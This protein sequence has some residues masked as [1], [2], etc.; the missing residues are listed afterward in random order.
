MPRFF[1]FDPDQVAQYEAAGWR[2]YYDRKWLLLLRLLLGLCQRQFHIPFPVSLLAAYHVVRAAAAWAPADHDSFQVRADYEQFYRLARRY[3][4][5]TFDPARVAALELAYNDVHRRLAG[6]PD[7][8]AFVETLVELHST[9]FGITPAQA[10]ESAELRVA[11]NT[12][13]DLI[14]SGTSTDVEA[15]WARLEDQLRQCYRSIRT[16]LRNR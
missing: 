2:A 8:S 13:V 12:T 5:L 4:G 1:T 9:L 15:D 14:T 7:K 3:S 10:R 11:A 16:H 6:K